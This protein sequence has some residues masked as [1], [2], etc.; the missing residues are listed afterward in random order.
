M[1]HPTTV[2]HIVI[3]GRE[4]IAEFKAKG[5]NPAGTC[6]KCAFSGLGFAICPGNR[7]QF[8]E[9]SGGD[10]IWKLNKLTHAVPGGAA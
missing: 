6:N 1:K 7:Q 3:D 5:A 10:F 2:K 4:F 8:M 9:C